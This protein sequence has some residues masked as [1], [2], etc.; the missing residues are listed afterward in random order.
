MVQVLDLRYCTF[1]QLPDWV[2]QLPSLQRLYL[3]RCKMPW[4]AMTWKSSAPALRSFHCT[5]SRLEKVCI[6]YSWHEL[7]L[8]SPCKSSSFL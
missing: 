6:A 7:A 8:R 2:P 5:N 3:E 4:Q 1:E